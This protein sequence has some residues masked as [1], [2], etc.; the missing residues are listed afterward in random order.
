MSSEAG[1]FSSSLLGAGRELEPAIPAHLRV[2]RTLPL[3][4]PPGFV[5]AH[6][7]FS[8]RF[9]PKVEGLTIAYYGLQS[10]AGAGELDEALARILAAFTRAD[11][12]LFWDVA[13]HIDDQRCRNR[14]VAAYWRDEAANRRWEQQLGPDWW[15]RGF[16][17]NGPLGSFREVIRP[18]LRDTETTFSHRHPEGYAKIADAMSGETDTHE[19]WGSARD[20]IPRTQTDELSPQ[21]RPAAST[22]VGPDT[23]GRL[24]EV[25]PHENL[26]LLRSGQDWSDTG[27]AERAFYLGQVKPL[28]DAGME[29]LNRDGARL[30]CYFNRYLQL[31]AERSYSLSAWH[32]LAELEA[33]VK[34]D[35]HLRIWAAGIKHYKRAGRDARL[36]LYHELAVLPA[37]NQSY[38]YFNCHRRTGMLNALSYGGAGVGLARL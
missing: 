23:R 34:A 19:Y 27:D 7:S 16:D 32:S 11:G 18:S 33:W 31:T 9:S 12:P 35:T 29:E 36:R 24:V 3:H 21:G 14:I 30:G 15:F 5:P 13:N 22:S 1:P 25:A 20:R 38:A 10:A 4:A 26:C 28:L 2:P 8:A 6:P 37:A 17:A